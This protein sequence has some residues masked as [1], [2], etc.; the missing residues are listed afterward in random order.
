MTYQELREQTSLFWHQS[1]ERARIERFARNKMALITVIGSLLAFYGIAVTYLYSPEQAEIINI[2]LITPIWQY[3]SS[4]LA[5]FGFSAPMT[6]VALG[7][8][9]SL[10]A[11]LFTT[12]FAMLHPVKQ[13]HSL[14]LSEEENLSNMTK[15][16]EQFF[17]NAKQRIKG[18]SD[19]F[20]NICWF[21]LFALIISI[22]MGVQGGKVFAG[23]CYGFLSYIILFIFRGLFIAVVKPFWKKDCWETQEIKIEAEFDSI[24]SESETEESAESTSE[25]IK[26]E[27]DS[28]D[29]EE[30]P[31]EHIQCEESKN[32]EQNE[33][34]EQIQENILA[35]ML[36]GEKMYEEAIASNPV[37]E[38]LMKQ[39]AKLG[40]VSACYYL[41]KNLLS[42]WLSDMYTAEEK[43]E[44]A[45]N[46]AKYFDVAR[47]IATLGKLDIK[48]ECQFLWLFSR[49]QY[50]SNTKSQWKQMLSDLR[51]VQKTGNLPEEYSGTLELAIKSVVN[52]IDRFDDQPASQPSYDT[53]PTKILYC[54][55]RNGAI[56]TKESGSAMIYHCNYVDCPGVCPT[57]R[58]S[59]G[60]GYR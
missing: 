59:G 22:A 9:S 39:A 7:V 12:I 47:Q 55:F 6:I 1:I 11:I 50:E 16:K 8:C 23:I 46:A 41:G 42:D 44:I 48:T 37:N 40:S 20:S 32:A 35:D 45:E 18:A 15:L 38:E 21:L 10:I 36:G 2:F 52:N 30:S 14:V 43:E 28:E 53:E 27:E 24:I 17:D 33:E 58:S 26:Q 3:S 19:N 56:C 25:N 4:L 51:D 49:L 31:E 5:K 13:S 57:A 54:K 60:L 29:I 34:V